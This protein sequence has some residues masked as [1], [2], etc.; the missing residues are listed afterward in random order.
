MNVPSALKTQYHA[1]LAM[2]KQTLDRC[3]APLWL[4]ADGPWLGSATP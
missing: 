3:P 2:L 1:A 4:A